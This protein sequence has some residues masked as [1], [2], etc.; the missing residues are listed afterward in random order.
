MKLATLLTDFT[1]ADGYPAVIKGVM[2]SITPEAR[3]VDLSHSIPPQDVLQAALLL[4]RS[5]P[6]FL[7]GTVHVCVAD[8]GVGT[9]QRGI[10]AQLGKQF[11]VGPD[12]GLMT[13]VYRKALAAKET[14]RI[15]SLE[16]PTYRLEP[17][18]RSFH[19]R[20]VF[21]PAAA[22]FLNGTPMEVFGGEITDPVFLHMPEPRKTENGWEGAVLHTDAFGNLTTTIRAEHLARKEKT[23][24]ILAGQTISGL[25]NAFG[26]GRHG[27]LVAIIDSDG[28]LSVCVVNGNAKQALDTRAGNS[29]QVLF[30]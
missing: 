12:N 30:S 22:Y 21:S 8:P 2:L 26:E 18:S 13:L 15:Y 5:A 23:Y 25:L 3:I 16:N 10:I 28:Y 14:V 19:G 27:D 6:Y 7:F 17:V 20:D 9:Q 1:D 4:G 11:F 24:I 29:V